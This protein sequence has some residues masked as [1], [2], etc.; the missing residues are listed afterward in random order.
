MF[1]WEVI[2]VVNLLTIVLKVLVM[3]ST[4]TKWCFGVKNCV[5]EELFRTMINDTSLP[6]YLWVYAINTTW[7]VSNSIFILSI[8]NKRLYELFKRRKLNL[9]CFRVFN[10][11]RFILN[12]GKDK[13]DKFNVKVDEWMPSTRLI[14]KRTRKGSSIFLFFMFQRYQLKI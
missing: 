10:F 5:L 8:L 11:K 9:S 13:L 4:T 14:P 2:M 3:N 1:L 12:I 6:K 7:H